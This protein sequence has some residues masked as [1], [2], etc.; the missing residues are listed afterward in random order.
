[1]GIQ[2]KD[3][4]AVRAGPDGAG[5]GV[6]GADGPNARI[7]SLGAAPSPLEVLGVNQTAGES[8][9]GIHLY[10][11]VYPRSFHGWVLLPKEPWGGRRAPPAPRG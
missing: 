8:L 11:G 2:S 4:A 9:G 3:E 7:P 5:A 6:H 10:E 1:M